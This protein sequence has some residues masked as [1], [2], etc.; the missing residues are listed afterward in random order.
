MIGC[1]VS[2]E[3]STMLVTMTFSVLLLLQPLLNGLVAWRP[4]EV[5]TA[6]QLTIINCGRKRGTRVA[7]RRKSSTG[8]LPRRS[9]VL[10]VAFGVS[11]LMGGYLNFGMTMA[12]F[13]ALL[14]IYPTFMVSELLVGSKISMYGAQACWSPTKMIKFTMFTGEM[15]VGRRK[16]LPS[17]SA[18][19]E[20]G[21]CQ[22]YLAATMA[23]STCFM[24]GIPREIH[25]AGTVPS[26]RFTC[27]T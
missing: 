2:G 6:L 27:T 11:L 3:T 23:R 24:G 19:R 26:M 16:K 25:H 22:Y 20:M 10:K 1:L 15:A 17:T 4:I 8:R 18:S 21:R 14:L 12:L 7:R 13:A 5:I 9:L